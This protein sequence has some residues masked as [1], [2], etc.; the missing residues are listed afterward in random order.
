MPWPYI[1]TQV[2]NVGTEE[3]PDFREMPRVLMIPG[4]RGPYQVCR[5]CRAGRQEHIDDFLAEHGSDASKWPEDAKVKPFKVEYVIMGS[6]RCAKHTLRFHR[7]EGTLTP[8]LKADILHR[9]EIH[10]RQR[11]GAYY[12]PRN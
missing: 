9:D 11:G 5:D 10:A 6:S 12:K 4:R 8:E 7:D 1:S 2:V 3:E